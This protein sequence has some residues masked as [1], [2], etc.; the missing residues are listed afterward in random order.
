M[1]K[2]EIL[3]IAPA[4]V[5]A[6]EKFAG[7]PYK[8]AEHPENGDTIK[9][10]VRRGQD[11]LARLRWNQRP[12]LVRRVVPP[13]GGPTMAMWAYPPIQPGKSLGEL[14]IEIAQDNILLAKE[15]VPYMMDPGVAAFMSQWIRGDIQQLKQVMYYKRKNH[16]YGDGIGDDT[17]YVQ[18]RIGEIAGKY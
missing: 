7:K 13:L 6:W 1:T 4:W 14:C 11:M 18:A 16:P 5:K 15:R 9:D 12:A 17:E 10:M 8:K 3:E 2:A